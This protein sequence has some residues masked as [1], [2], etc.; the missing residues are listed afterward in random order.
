M[1]QLGYIR[2]ID[3][4]RAIA[5]MMVVVFHWFAGGEITHS[6]MGLIGVDIFFAVSGFLI[7]RIL[8]VY[9]INHDSGIDQ[10]SKI[11]AV[12]KF[13]FRRALRIF[14]AYFLLLFFLYHFGNFL[15]NTLKNDLKWYLAYLQNFLFYFRQSWP[16][17][18]LSPFWTLAVEEQF[19]LVWPWLVLFV[20][21][22]R[23]IILISGL[24]LTGIISTY[25]FPLIL[26]KK[27]MIDVITPTCLHAFGAGAIVAYLHIFKAS[28]FEKKGYIFLAVGLGLIF[29]SLFT[30]LNNINIYIDHR[31]LVS[32]GTAFLLCYLL[33]SSSGFFSEFVLGNSLLVWVGKISYGIYLY[34]NF[35]P[36]YLN[37][38]RVWLKQYHPDAF[39]LPY[40]PNRANGEVLFFTICFV[41]LFILAWGSFRFFEKPLLNFKSVVS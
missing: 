26:Q 23:L 5:V 40:F 28:I 30:R 12:K 18:K 3:G 27:L 36:G 35:I 6:G 24:L 14:P 7:T 29:L 39:I 37:G 31:S 41:L 32:F 10:R 4:L 22:K 38:I 11:Y 1:H 25:F 2:Q 33:S 34:H 17:G 15:P 20:P 9:K 16:V 8:I 21:V 19:Y 13:M